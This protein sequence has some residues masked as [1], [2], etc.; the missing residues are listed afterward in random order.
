MIREVLLSLVYIIFFIWII[1]KGKFF[2][3]EGISRN[4]FAGVFI[5]KILCGIALQI[6]YTKY[7]TDRNEA[8]IYKFFYYSLKG[9]KKELFVA[10]FAIPSVLLWSSGLLKESFEL[11]VLGMLLYIFYLII[12]DKAT[13][14]RVSL[15]LAFLFLHVLIKFYILL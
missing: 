11:F 4:W 12:H 7:Y 1:K 15:L 9:K 10:I 3:V 14:I 13:V 2:S 8:G 5:L 6:I